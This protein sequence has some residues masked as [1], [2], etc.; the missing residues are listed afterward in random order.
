MVTPNWDNHRDLPYKEC[1]FIVQGHTY[2]FHHVYRKN[3]HLYEI[4]KSLPDVAEVQWTFRADLDRGHVYL[5]FNGQSI[6]E[7]VWSNI[8][9]LSACAPM[10]GVRVG[11]VVTL[12]SQYM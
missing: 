1:A 9:W 2:D 4:Y 5:T 6:E 12:S 3:H 10:I 11:G 7:P 8:P